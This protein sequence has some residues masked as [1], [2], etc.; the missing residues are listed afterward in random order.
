MTKCEKGKIINP[1]TGRCVK[2]DGAIG[3]TLRSPAKRSATKRSA[4]K[5]SA[6]KRSASKRSASKK[7]SASPA[8][9]SAS[10]R[11]ASKRSASKRSASKG[12]S[13]KRSVSMKS[14]AKYTAEFFKKSNAP[15]DDT[16]FEIFV[17]KEGRKDGEYPQIKVKRSDTVQEVKAKITRKLGIPAR[18]QHIYFA[19]KSFQDGHTLA[20]YNVE[21]DSTLHVFRNE[22][23]KDMLW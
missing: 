15:S 11:S 5:R 13:P 10:K 16:T 18:E 21:P 2:A 3:R 1:A 12:A 14:P 4:T 9:R 7:S 6:S 17:F 22:V 8:K 23:P 19:G 20:E